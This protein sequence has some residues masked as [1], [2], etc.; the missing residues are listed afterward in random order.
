MDAVVIDVLRSRINRHLNL[1]MDVLKKQKGKA[2]GYGLSFYLSV[3]IIRWFD[4]KMSNN[5][6]A[7]H[8][9]ILK[10]A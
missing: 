10:K 8:T 5:A 4:H 2:V 9:A 7:E 6:A 3:D 1:Y